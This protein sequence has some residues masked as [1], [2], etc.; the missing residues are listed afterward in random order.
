MKY[1]VRMR[2]SIIREYD[3]EVESDSVV[4][5]L[6]LAEKLMPVRERNNELFFEEDVEISVVEWHPISLG[7]K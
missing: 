5:A 6:N 3:L 2:K 1:V 7:D 4:N